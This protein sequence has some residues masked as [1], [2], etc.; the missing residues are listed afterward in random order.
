MGYFS[1][2]IFIYF[3]FKYGLAFVT[4]GVAFER[5]WSREEQVHKSLHV[6]IVIRGICGYTSLP[7]TVSQGY[8]HLMYFIFSPHHTI[9]FV[10]SPSL[11]HMSS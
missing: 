11:S 2:F 8:F 4:N 1:C 3:R 10:L 6:R 7:F 5:L 9:S